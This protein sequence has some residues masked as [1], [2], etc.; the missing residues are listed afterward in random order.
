MGLKHDQALVMFSTIA[1][2]LEAMRIEKSFAHVEMQKT[3]NAA[4]MDC[5]MAIIFWPGMTNRLWVKEKRDEFHKF[6]GTADQRGFSI[7]SLSKVCDRLIID[8]EEISLFGEKKALRVP[9]IEKLAFISSFCDPEG[10]N[11]PAYEKADFL[12][13]ELYKLI[14]WK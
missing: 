9:L 10:S 2:C 4:F 5:Q 8:L 12:L 1:G 13:D 3:I 14:E 7:C 6:I 11:F